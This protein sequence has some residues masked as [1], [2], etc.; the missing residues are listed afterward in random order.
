MDEVIP[1]PN[2]KALIAERPIFQGG[3]FRLDRSGSTQ[4][5]SVRADIERVCEY[6]NS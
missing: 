5:E 2:C 3:R 4:N 6:G 1:A